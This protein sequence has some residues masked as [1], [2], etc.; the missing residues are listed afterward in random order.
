[1]PAAGLRRATSSDAGA[2][3][4]V[5]ID[6]WQIAYRG[7][8]P[9][10]VLDSLRLEDRTALWRRRLTDGDPGALTPVATVDATIV[11]YCRLAAPSRDDDAGR[12]TAEIASIY[13]APDRR[14]QGIGHR[15][16]CSSVAELRSG[17]WTEATLWVFSA[18]AAAR[19]FYAV[20][21]FAP[22][23]RTGYDELCELD[24]LRLRRGLEVRGS[25]RPGPSEPSRRSWPPCERTSPVDP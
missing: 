25:R 10:R 18:N 4:R 13:I 11:G 6:G 20:H 8:V 2:I 17:G 14:H 23:G 12:R 15:L 21:G 9:D 1:M 7:L 5:W 24:E 22:D 16:L 3:A 19:A